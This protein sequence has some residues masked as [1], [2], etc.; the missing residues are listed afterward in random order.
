M[1]IPRANN[2]AAKSRA[3]FE[4]EHVV[5]ITRVRIPFRQRVI[6]EDGQTERGTKCHGDI[7]CG[8]FVCPDRRSRPVE[9]ALTASSRRRGFRGGADALSEVL[10]E[11]LIWN[12]HDGTWRV[13]SGARQA[14]L[15]ARRGLCL[16]SRRTGIVGG[17]SVPGRRPLTHR[18]R[19]RQPLSSR[20][21][22]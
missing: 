13:N 6:D 15:M 12:G 17:G 2:S 14:Y 10:R 19:H 16:E 22:V 20:R 4:Y 18:A 8:I 11:Q 7:E 21:T 1:P 3:P 9:N 5:P